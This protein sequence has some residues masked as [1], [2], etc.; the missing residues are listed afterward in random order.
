MLQ[1]PNQFHST[2][3]NSPLRLLCTVAHPCFVQT[4]HPQWS[5]CTTQRRSGGAI[6]RSVA[7]RHWLIRPSQTQTHFAY[8]PLRVKLFID[9]STRGYRGQKRGVPGEHPILRAILPIIE[10]VA[11]ERITNFLN[12][13]KRTSLHNSIF[14]AR[15][16]ASDQ[17]EGCTISPALDTLQLA[18]R[19]CILQ[20]P[21]STTR[22]RRPVTPSWEFYHLLSTPHL[23]SLF[24][25]TSRFLMALSPIL[26]LL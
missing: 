20:Q 5:T 22:P 25:E 7:A 26:S 12:S 4:V 6:I 24:F 14:A 21:A 1:A 9:N 18:A 10:P 23:H 3:T 16:P 8:S 13:Y 17:G 15:A 11:G 19:T 2:R